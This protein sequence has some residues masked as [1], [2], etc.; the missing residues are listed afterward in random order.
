MIKIYN[1]FVRMLYSIRFLPPLLFRFILAYGFLV[2][3][4][5]KIENFPGTVEFFN[6][7]HIPHPELSAYL[8]VT[9]EGLGVLFLF[10]GFATRL[11]TIPLIFLLCVAI[12]TVH[13]QHGFAAGHNG[14]EIPLYYILMLF[15]LLV[16]GPGALSIDAYIR[17]QMERK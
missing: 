11:I 7:L 2:P 1:F 15:S 12:A 8:S 4:L 14:F 16:S 13:W 6:Q 5:A 17:G 3:F 9:F 10:F